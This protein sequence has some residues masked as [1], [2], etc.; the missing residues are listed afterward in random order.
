MASDLLVNTPTMSVKEIAYS[1]GFFDE[2]H[3]SKAFKT[4]TGLCPT[5]FRRKHR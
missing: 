2:Y 5:A 3:F 1:L 4:R